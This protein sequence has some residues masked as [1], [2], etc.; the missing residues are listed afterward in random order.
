MM[1]NLTTILMDLLCYLSVEP[2]NG[3]DPDETADLQIN[4]WQTLIHDLT[5]EESAL[6]KDAA[7]LKLASM[8]GIQNPTQEQEPV[9]D[10]LSAFVDGE[11]Q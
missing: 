6:I 10:I 7:R 2:D 11:L 3:Y 4:A 9:M 5:E 8:E 1:K